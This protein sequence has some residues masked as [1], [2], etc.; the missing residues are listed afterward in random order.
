MAGALL[1]LLLAVSIS[2]QQTSSTVRGRIADT[3]GGVI[4]GAVVTLIDEQNV[5]KT[6]VTDEAGTYAFKAVTPGKY[7]LRVAAT[8]FAPYEA[9]IEVTPNMREEFDVNLIVALSKQDD[10]TVTTGTTLNTDPDNNASGTVLRDADLDALPDDPDE[11]AATLRTLAGPSAG[12]SGAQIYI[13]G[14]TAEGRLPPK[15]SIKEIS[16]NQNPFTAEFERLGF[17]RIQITT[18]PGTDKFHGLAMLHFSDQ[19]LNSRN[20]F[21]PINAPFQARYYSG[22]LSGPLFGKRSSFFANFQRRETD[23]NAFINAVILDPSLNPVALNEAVLMP[24]RDLFSSLRVD[25]QINPN[26]TLLLN[27]SYAPGKV[28]NSGIGNFTLQSRALTASEQPHTFR[29]TETSILNPSVVNETRMQYFYL[30]RKVEGD[31]STPTISVLDAFTGGGATVGLSSFKAKQWELH[32]YT[33]WALGK[34][35]LR[36]G[37]RF[38]YATFTDVSPTNFNGTFTF[39]GG[40]EPGAGGVPVAIGSL[41]RYRRTLLLQQQGFSPAEIRARGGGATLFS[42]AQGDPVASVSQSD[43]GI[44]IQEDR[45]LRPNFTLSLGLRYEAQSNISSNFNFA[46]RISFAWAPGQQG[47][48]VSKTVIRGGVG[49]FYDRVSPTLTL[50]ANRFDGIRQQQFIVSDTAILDLFPNVPTPQ[51]LNAFA[52]PQSIRR[53]SDN[54][55]APFTTQLALSL[56]RQLPGKTTLALTYIYAD[57]RHLLRTRNVNAP[58]PGTFNAGDT[59]QAVRPLGNTANVFEFE[60]NGIFKQHQFLV[61]ITS[62]LTKK[63]SFS[64]NYAWNK[65]DSNTDGVSSFPADTY[66][67]D[68]EYGRSALDVRHRINLTASYDTFW[69]LNLN[70]LVIWRTGIPFNITT[71]SDTNGDTQFTERPAFAT[72]L[73]RPGVVLTRFGNFDLSPIPGQVIVPRNYGDGPGFFGVNFGITKTFSLGSVKASAAA[74][75]RPGAPGGGRPAAAVSQERP[76]KLSFSIRFYNLFNHNNLGPR[77]G[78]LSSPLFG[79]SNTTSTEVNSNNA[80]SNRRI[81]L[82]TSFTF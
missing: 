53:L 55:A 47:S 36:F 6:A 31:S 24:R 11:L 52:V 54:L 27:Y 12:P 70:T 75:A 48:G 77:I 42:L 38:R 81:W 20:P 21:A 15:S 37:G 9:S 4:G 71:G 41:E 16:I 39:A 82:Q 18:R 32:N 25:Y 33:T 26:N 64:M 29:L 44:F 40:L 10:V 76:Y 45:R 23:D 66:N 22:A 74:P 5:E 80:T 73:N 62:R 65:A 63:L 72:D 1:C 3:L 28:S 59:S 30:S 57:A 35:T 8:S 49:I 46:P 78:N 2:A 56:E 34:R 68:G 61:N 69:G 58:F 7:K 67:L 79:E 51:M 13:D 50:Q 43:L 14:F 19:R 60:S 17:G